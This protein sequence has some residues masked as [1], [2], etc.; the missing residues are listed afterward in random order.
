MVELWLNLSSGTAEPSSNQNANIPTSVQN[1]QMILNEQSNEMEESE[2]ESTTVNRPTSEKLFSQSKPSTSVKCNNKAMESESNTSQSLIQTYT[3]KYNIKQEII[4]A[5]EYRFNDHV[6]TQVEI[7]TTECV[8]DGTTSSL[9]NQNTALLEQNDILNNIDEIF[10]GDTK[11]VPA[12]VP[13][14]KPKKTFIKCLDTNGK[15]ILAELVIDQQNPKKFK[16]IRT[17]NAVN[18]PPPVNKV[19]PTPNIHN[20][21]PSK[22]TSLNLAKTSNSTPNSSIIYTPYS[23]SPLIKP[24]T[25]QQPSAISIAPKPAQQIGSSIKVPINAQNII[26]KNGKIFVIKTPTAAATSSIVKPKPKQESLLKP[27]IS[28]LKP[29]VNQTLT[30]K[31]TFSTPVQTTVVNTKNTPSMPFKNIII[32]NKNGEV[33]K[34]QILPSTH[35]IANHVLGAKSIITKPNQQFN[36]KQFIITNVKKEYRK[37]LEHEFFDCHNFK[38]IRCAVEYLLMKVPLVSKLATNTDY[39]SAFPFSTKTI[40]IFDSFIWPKQRALEVLVNNLIL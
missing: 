29:I 22:Y 12:I 2:N 35:K 39:I 19:N 16:I 17:P 28:L 18:G 1:E 32:T 5:E 13:V 4:E 27:Q 31:K 9:P 20:T 21:L 36:H 15:V 23:G 11:P 30:T 3:P 34:V 33:K 6:E 38:T 10:N 7:S 14:S 37:D 25:Q 40:E 8:N 26:M 24:M